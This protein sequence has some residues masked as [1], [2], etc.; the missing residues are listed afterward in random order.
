MRVFIS[1]SG[2]VSKEIGQ[3]I[4]DW[5]PNVIQSVRPYFTPQ[6]IEKGALWLSE[7]R[8][9]L[10]KSKVGIFIITRDNLTSQWLHFE[11][12]AIS[13]LADRI[14]VCPLLFGIELTDVKGP[15]SQFQATVFNRNEAF[16]LVTTVNNLLGDQK[17]PDTNLDKIFKKWWPELDSAITNIMMSESKNGHE[18]LRTDRDLIEEMLQT[19]RVISSATQITSSQN[20]EVKKA[21][22]SFAMESVE[23]L[24]EIIFAKYSS[25]EFTNKQIERINGFIYCVKFHCEESE[26]KKRFIDEIEEKKSYLNSHLKKLKRKNVKSTIDDD[27]PF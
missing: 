12:G 25:E 10:D 16:K 17:L 23:R 19:I 22:I 24:E 2:D 18:N 13:S 14:S 11:A 3:A 20:K 4:R 26:M 27:I 7:I 1:W 15:L 5:L 21:D 6:D 9:E 8:S